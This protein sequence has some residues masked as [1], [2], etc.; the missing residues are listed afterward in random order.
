MFLVLFFGSVVKGAQSWFDFGGFSFQPSDPAKIVLI[1]VLA[2]YFTRRHVE[3][4]HIRHIFVSGLYALAIF[5]LVF[6]QPD[7]GSAITIFCIWLGLVMI[8]GISKNSI[9]P[10]NICRLLNI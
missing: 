3:I 9:G 6:L 5:T 2:K 8:S 7:F 4:A 1:L 10:K